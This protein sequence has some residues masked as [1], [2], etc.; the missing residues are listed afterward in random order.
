MPMS[1]RDGTDVLSDNTRTG[2]TFAKLRLRRHFSHYRFYLLWSVSQLIISNK[3]RGRPYG[4]VDACILE[5]IILQI[6]NHEKW[7]QI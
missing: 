6:L 3:S 5:Q 1:A 2:A 4:L 7:R